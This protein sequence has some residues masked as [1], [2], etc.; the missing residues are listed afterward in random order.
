M[1]IGVWF[2]LYGIGKYYG[3]G[4]VEQKIFTDS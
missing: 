3:V 4:G 2:D 1:H